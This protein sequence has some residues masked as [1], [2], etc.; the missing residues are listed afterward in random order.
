MIYLTFLLFCFCP[1]FKIVHCHTCVYF[2]I[3]FQWNIP[4]VYLD[5]FYYK[6]ASWC[7]IWYIIV[8]TLVNW[9]IYPWVI[10]MIVS[11]IEAQNK[12]ITL[13]HKIVTMCLIKLFSMYLCMFGCSY[14]FYAM[15]GVIWLILNTSQWWPILQ[16]ICIFLYNKDWKMIKVHKMPDDTILKCCWFDILFRVLTTSLTTLWNFWGWGLASLNGI[17]NK[18]LNTICYYI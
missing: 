3:Y 1:K 12:S 18:L 15:D 11:D 5:I 17:Q 10:P 6:I 9:H 13:L 2:C 8:L 16:F 7:A 14:E 4:E